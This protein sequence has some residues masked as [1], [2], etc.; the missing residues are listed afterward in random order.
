MSLLCRLGIHRYRLRANVIGHWMPVRL[1][2]RCHA[3]K[4]SDSEAPQ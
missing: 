4:S 3:L 2:T 1:C